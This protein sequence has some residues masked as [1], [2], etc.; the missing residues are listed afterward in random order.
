MAKD[1]IGVALNALNRV[2]GSDV[3]NRLGLRKPAERVA[4]TATKTGFM[5]ITRATRAFSRSRGDK[6]ARLALPGQ[7]QELFDLNISDEQQMIRDSVQQFA[8]EVL[9]PAAHGADHELRTPDA[10][11]SSAQ[12]LGLALFS[13]PEQ[14]GGA[15]AERSM[16]TNVLVAE[17]LAC[18]DMGLALS[19][20]APLSVANALTH[21][22]TG[23]QQSTYL[24][25]F[26]SETGHTMTASIVVNE[27]AALFNPHQ[28]R[29]T[30]V[31][32]GNEWILNGVKSL[33]PLAGRAE[34][35]LVAAR[36][37]RGPRIFIVEAGNKGISLRDGRGMGL[38]A[39]ELGD[40]QFDDVRL[41]ADAIL[42]DDSFDY[43]QF[44]DFGSLGW[45]ALAAGTMQAVL[46]YVIPYCNE[47]TAF[48]EPIS[49]RQSV[50]F[51]VANIAIELDSVRL[52][53]W[54]AAS[55][56]D[57]GMEMHREVFL[58]R[59]LAADKAVEVG[60]NGVQLLGGHGFTKEHPV[61]RWFRDLRAIAVMHGGLHL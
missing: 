39:A 22:G 30:A 19:I 35:F 61:E 43:A 1:P 11:L 47:R 14:H 26:V 13:V 8:R 56:F 7:T 29:T 6:P 17:D 4:Y 37:D 51:M 49:H 25:A 50:A 5:A 21:W 40:M 58:A 46:D 34:L 28:L 41:P 42:G 20:L 23:V 2:A 32:N 55:R 48:G 38:R 3:V 24:P 12:D 53:G 33:V 54:R 27:P 44:I 60:S 57:A 10:L 52:L 36:T 15:A 16:V 9:R 59:T 31:R 45:T 18:G